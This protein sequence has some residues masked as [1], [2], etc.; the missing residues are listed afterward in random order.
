MNEILHF[1]IIR[2]LAVWLIMQNGHV[3]GRCLAISYPGG[4]QVDLHDFLHDVQQKRVTATDY[5]EGA[6]KALEGMKFRNQKIGHSGLQIL[7][8][9]GYDIIRAI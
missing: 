7:N 3:E 2:H 5:Y 8:V 1:P 9:I 6:H 4:V